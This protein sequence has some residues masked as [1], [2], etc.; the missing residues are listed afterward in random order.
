MEQ[1]GARDRKVYICVRLRVH[2]T[3]KTITIVEDVY[4]LLKAAKRGDESFSE[5]IRRKLSERKDIMEFA[6]AWGSISD[7][8][9]ERMK[10]TIRKNRDLATKE[11]LR[12]TKR[13]RTHS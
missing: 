9:A 3:T 5:V 2:M 1:Q 10:E 8:E 13:W 11:L 4:R 6:G 12:K 7:P